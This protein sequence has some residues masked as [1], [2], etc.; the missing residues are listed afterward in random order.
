[1]RTGEHTYAFKDGGDGRLI[2]V[3]IK[4]GT[5]G[6]GFFE[7]IAGLAEGDEVVTSANFLVD[8][9]SS[10]KAALQAMAKDGQKESDNDAGEDA[11]KDAGKDAGGH[12]H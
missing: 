4:I 12:R 3:E 11:G 6:D 7:L 2:P 9:E 1:M 8:S 10:L 5:R